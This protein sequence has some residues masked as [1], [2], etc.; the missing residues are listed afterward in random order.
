MQR[1]L[2]AIVLV[3]AA[4]GA[5]STHVSAHA[6]QSPAAGEAAAPQG[7]SAA[8]TG[9]LDAAQQ[10]PEVKDGKVVIN[11]ITFEVG[12]C[13]GKLGKVAEVKVPEGMMFTDGD[14]A[15]RALV[16]SQNLASGDEVGMIVSTTSNWTVFFQFNDIGYV[17]DDDKDDIDADKLLDQYKEGISAGNEE[18]EK[19][20]WEK[21]ELI[22][23][24]KPPFYDTRTHNLTWSLLL[25]GKDS[26]SVNWSTRLLGRKGTMDVDLVLSPQD[27]DAALP[28]FEKLL[29]GFE[30]VEGESYAEFRSGDKVAE[31]GLAALIAGGAGAVA[32]KTGILAKFWK[33]IVGVVAAAFVGLKRLLG[34]GKKDGER[35]T[36]A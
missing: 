30:Y 28:E 17:K 7:G 26:E 6:S 5:L 21:L 18:R 3:L 36:P 32:Y 1:N 23:W 20:G 24:H 35:N 10:Q 31:Y 13:L 33:V 11:G 16:L 8:A 15:R 29:D 4:G 19:R 2:L 14:G 9:D 25:K 12:P 27:V 34:F 22:G